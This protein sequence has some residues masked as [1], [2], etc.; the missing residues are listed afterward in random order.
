M[1]DR[2]KIT[3]KNPKIKFSYAKQI[4]RDSAKNPID[5]L[6]DFDYIIGLTQE[7]NNIIKWTGIDLLGNLASVLTDE[8]VA[9]ILPM[10]KDFLLS[11]K[12]ILSNHALF[13]LGQILLQKPHFADEIVPMFLALRNVKFD[14]EDCRDISRGKLLEFLKENYRFIIGN[15]E[16]KEFIEKCTTSTREN[17]AKLAKQV[18]KKIKATT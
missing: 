15:K 13:A 7:K 11:G 12:L 1:I 4:V 14:T 6:N 2:E 5:F 10:L 18:L 9:K 3:S 17:V 16:A 8:N